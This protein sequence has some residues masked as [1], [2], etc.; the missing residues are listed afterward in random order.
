MHKYTDVEITALIAHHNALYD[1]VEEELAKTN[2]KKIPVELA[3]E[4]RASFEKLD[5]LIRTGRVSM[6]F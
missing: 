5:E 6:R 2:G 3:R 1:R 4:Y